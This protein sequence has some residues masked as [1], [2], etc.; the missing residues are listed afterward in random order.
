[1]S[2]PGYRITAVSKCLSENTHISIREYISHN[3][4]RG[5]PRAQYLFEIELIVNHTRIVRLP[6]HQRPR[7]AE[8]G[9]LEVCVGTPVFWFDEWPRLIMF[10][11]LW[12]EAHNAHF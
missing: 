3:R 10:I 2:P 5:Q 12:R 8:K 1:L 6:V 11:E 9:K 4:P 7:I